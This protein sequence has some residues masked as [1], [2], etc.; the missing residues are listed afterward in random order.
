THPTAKHCRDFLRSVLR[1]C[2]RMV[3]TCDISEEWK[4]HQSNFARGWRASM[5][6]HKKVERC[7]SVAN[8]PLR[9]IVENV[10][11]HNQGRDVM[12]KDMH[13]IEAALATDQAIVSL[14]EEARSLFVRAAKS[15]G[16]L[17]NIA[18][19]NPNRP[20]EEPIVWLEQGAKGEKK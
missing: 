14:D 18:W 5:E 3:M 16:R 4:A 7:G 2:H 8:T 1:V 6:A 12:R 9:T 15:V 10:A 19:V 13:L 17:R 11:T 20:D